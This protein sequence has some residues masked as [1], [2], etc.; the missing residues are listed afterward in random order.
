MSDEYDLDYFIP[1]YACWGTGRYFGKTSM[2]FTK[3]IK[4]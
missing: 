1:V 3:M 2:C 4:D